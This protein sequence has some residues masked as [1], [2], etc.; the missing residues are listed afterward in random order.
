MRKVTTIFITVLLITSICCL[1]SHGQNASENFD[2]GLDSFEIGNFDAAIPYFDKA[3][4]Q[5][6]NFEKAYYIRGRCF[7]EKEN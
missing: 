6:S 3:I 4:E 7:L 5:K 1:E 2:L